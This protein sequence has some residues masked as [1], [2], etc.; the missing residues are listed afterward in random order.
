MIIPPDTK[1][2][3]IDTK[4]KNRE[5]QNSAWVRHCKPFGLKLPLACLRFCKETL[6]FG[7]VG[8]ERTMSQSLTDGAPF[9]QHPTGLIGEINLTEPLVD[10]FDGLTGGVKH[11]GLIEAV[12]AQLIE[13][14][15]IRRKI[16]H[17]LSGKTTHQP[18]DRQ[19]QNSL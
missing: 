8:M 13:Y 14:N 16:N 11:V 5:T 15:L 10:V 18:V 6:V 3:V 17:A 19:E 9:L 4:D 7:T 2:Q 1:V 12:I